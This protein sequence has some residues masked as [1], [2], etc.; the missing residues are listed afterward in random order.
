MHGRDTIIVVKVISYNCMSLL[1]IIFSV[2]A[3]RYILRFKKLACARFSS[4][5]W[6]IASSCVGIHISFA[7][8]QLGLY[9]APSRGRHIDNPSDSHLRFSLFISCKLL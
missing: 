5:S 8:Q 6:A 2:K 9:I 7:H 4:E 1:V 3:N